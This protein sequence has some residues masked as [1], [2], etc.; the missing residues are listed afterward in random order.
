[1]ADLRLR[2]MLDQVTG[3]SDNTSCELL[4]FKISSI[5]VR[6]L[7]LYR[8]IPGMTQAVAPH[9]LYRVYTRM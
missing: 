8:F 4:R 9:I 1:M 6:V 3:P 2:L 5:I 7:F